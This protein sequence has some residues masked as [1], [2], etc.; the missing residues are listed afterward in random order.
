MPRDAVEWKASA[1]STTKP[2]GTRPGDL[3]LSFMHNGNRTDVVTPPTGWTLIGSNNFPHQSGV[4]NTYLFAAYRLWTDSDAATTTVTW[5]G[6]T[7]IQWQH[8]V[9][10]RGV[11]QTNPIG[12]I[13]DWKRESSPTSTPTH[14]GVTCTYGG[15]TILYCMETDDSA[16]TITTESTGFTTRIEDGS[17]NI[18]EAVLDGTAT[19]SKT[20]LSWT[21]SASDS[22]STIVVE[23][24][25]G[26]ARR[27]Y[28]HA[29]S[30]PSISPAIS[31]EWETSGGP[32]YRILT[33]TRSTS[34]A[35]KIGPVTSTGGDEQDACALV[36]IIGPTGTGILQG[37][38]RAQMRCAESSAGANFRSHLI[39]RVLDSTG[40]ELAVARAGDTTTNEQADEWVVAATSSG[41]TNR[42]FPRF[43][44]AHALTSTAYS[45]GNFISVEIG[46][47]KNTATA[48]YTLSVGSGDDSATDLA[49]TSAGTAAN[50]PWVEF[51]DGVVLSGEGPDISQPTQYVRRY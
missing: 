48:T 33:D 43:T 32:T 3:L 14:N 42:S 31:S 10:Y 16:G 27:F 29:T 37:Y 44:K 20:S 12:T 34:A 26:N 4:T 45:E 19:M 2:T 40:G 38:V 51:S 22:W 7:A 46:C 1:T 35:N 50:N 21:T 41:M 15:S 8:N 30:T 24:H 13:G 28:W 39:V 47:R 36:G 49:E 11:D 18:G 23:I 17:A 6:A 25:G 9:C 5:N